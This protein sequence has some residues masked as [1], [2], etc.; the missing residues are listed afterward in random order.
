MSID[1]LKKSRFW[2]MEIFDLYLGYEVPWWNEVVNIPK[3]KLPKTMKYLQD[4]F[5]V[6]NTVFEG[7]RLFKA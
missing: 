4:N 5:T 3:S 6:T 2:T 1:R 7:V